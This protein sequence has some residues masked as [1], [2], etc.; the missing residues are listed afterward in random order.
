MDKNLI[1]I[2]GE[3]I[4]GLKKIENNSVNLIIADPPYNLNKNYGKTDDNLEFE[5]YLDFSR[6]WL[7]EAKRILKDNGTIYVFLDNL[8]LYSRNW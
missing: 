7:I 2:C 1:L 5:E 3:A 4:E 6:N 8:A